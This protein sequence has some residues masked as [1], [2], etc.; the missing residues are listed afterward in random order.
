[1]LSE[2]DACNR[3]SANASVSVSPRMKSRES[4]KYV[5]RSL[6]RLK[7][8]L[9]NGRAPLVLGLSGAKCRSSSSPSLPRW[10]RREAM[11]DRW[12]SSSTGDHRTPVVYIAFGKQ[13]QRM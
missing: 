8:W 7:L 11:S 1:M 12:N 10:G 3:T 6:D 5:N 13:R 4:R 2:G 9:E